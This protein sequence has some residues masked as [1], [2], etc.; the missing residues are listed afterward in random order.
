MSLRKGSLTVELVMVE[1]VPETDQDPLDRILEKE[2]KADRVIVASL[3]RFTEQARLLAMNRKVQLWDRA[4]L[5]EEVG[6]MVMGEVDTRPAAPVEDSLLEPFIEGTLAGLGPDDAGASRD[7]YAG[8]QGG[9]QGA[10]P[11]TGEPPGDRG[12]GVRPELPDGEAMVRP[13][14]TLEQAREMVKD[15]LE[16]AFRFD[17]QLLPH[18]VLAYS[19]EIDG[20]GGTKVERTGGI[21]VN[22]ISGDASEWR[23]GATMEKLEPGRIRI[24]PS[25]ERATATRNALELVMS[26]HTRVVNLKQEKRSVTVYEKRTMRPRDNAVLLEYKGML[27]IPV[28][29]VEASEGAAVLDAITGR[30]IK[31][32]VFNPRPAASDRD[33]G[34]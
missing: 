17:L 34:K 5:E 29:C 6:R 10:I 1:G 8:G 23:P 24:E 12:A 20:P 21:L 9:T 18:H 11:A 26:L 28:W 27:Y 19:V 3:G 16:G 31:E 25:V 22:A 30:V 15:R 2:R 7:Q 32:E 33:S 4:H 14:I 13:E